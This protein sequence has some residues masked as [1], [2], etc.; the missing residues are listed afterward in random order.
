MR[1]IYDGTNGIALN[2]GIKIRDQIRFP[3]A[4]DVKCVLSECA[5]EGGPHSIFDFDVDKAHRR[6]PVLETEGGRQACQVKGSAAAT[7]QLKRSAEAAT[8]EK[9]GESS[10]SATPAPLSLKDISENKLAEEV[11][12]NTVGTFGVTSAGYW[13]GCA[14]GAAMRLAHYVI[15]YINAVYALLYSDDGKVIGRTEQYE[16]GIITLSATL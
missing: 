4:P 11:F 13:W 15:G 1:V 2:R 3:I 14:G 6:C 9:S 10:S 7:A 12:L 8:R 16:R 5:E